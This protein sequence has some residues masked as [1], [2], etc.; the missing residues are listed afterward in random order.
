[1]VKHV[2]LNSKGR[3]TLR[4]SDLF[5]VFCKRHRRCSIHWGDHYRAMKRRR[6]PESLVLKC[7]DH[8]STLHR[9]PPLVHT[10]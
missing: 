5:S 7:K 3:V 9:D 6:D 8:G 1:M 2:I 10:K 4:G